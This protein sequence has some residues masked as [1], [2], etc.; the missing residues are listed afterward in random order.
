MGTGNYVK[1]DGVQTVC[2]GDTV[3][4]GLDLVSGLI[5]T[6]YSSG[7]GDLVFIGTSNKMLYTYGGGVIRTP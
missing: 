6:V 5:T 4:S 1:F 2:S 3:T 7:G